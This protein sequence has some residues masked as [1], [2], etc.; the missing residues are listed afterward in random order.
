MAYVQT[1][2]FAILGLLGVAFYL[3]AYAA[4]QFGFLRGSSYL[5]TLMNLAGAV[6]VLI[7][8]SVEFNMASAL[9]QIS[10]ITIS[11]IGLARLYMR[12]RGLRFSED[13]AQFLHER[14]P[15]LSKPSA[16]DFFNAGGWVDVP[17]GE[18][19][20][21]EGAPVGHLFYL[22]RGAASVNSGGHQITRIEKGFVGEINVIDGAP[23]SATVTTLEPVHAFVIAREDLQRLVARDVEFKSALETSLSREMG[24][25]LMSANR[26]IVGAGQA[27]PT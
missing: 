21:R 9:I 27:D 18:V 3:G 8:L 14:F 23:A 17:K 11:V 4:L 24:Q 6:L 19:L 13:E 22:A 25:R 5:Y 1:D 26:Q 20:L 10:W 7:S 15:A 16:R 12:N 2:T